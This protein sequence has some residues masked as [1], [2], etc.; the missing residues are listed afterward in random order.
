MTE[1][2]A[3]VNHKGM[4]PKLILIAN[5]FTQSSIAARVQEAV[6]AGIRWVHLR[7]HQ[8][9]DADFRASTLELVAALRGISPDIMISVNGRL[10]IANE[11]GLH[12]HTGKHNPFDVERINHKAGYSAHSIQE[13]LYRI[14]EGADYLFYSPI[15]P[16]SSKP[17]HAGVGVQHLK[18]F[19]EAVAPLPVYALGGITPNNCAACL[20]AGAYGVA[21]LS[22]I[23]E[24]NSVP[25]AVHAYKKGLA[26]N[27]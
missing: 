24:A 19:C 18:M 16:T 25:D 2:L 21:V 1:E 8:A 13:G 27:D 4:L 7:D 10:N 23:L 26:N 14:D 15:F 5:Q 17:G 3:H 6:Q 12:Y 20:D 9:S 22:G 11:L